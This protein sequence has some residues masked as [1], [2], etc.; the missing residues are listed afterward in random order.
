MS[1]G[2]ALQPAA[3]LMLA[4]LAVL[5]LVL[6]WKWLALAGVARLAWG[7]LYG[8]S[9]QRRPKAS[10]AKTI[11]AWSLLVVAWNTRGLVQK[12]PRRRAGFRSNAPARRQR[13]RVADDDGVPF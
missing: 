12:P 6:F 7:R 10:W 2:R 4:G 8:R 1:G 9:R 13:G 5:A 3:V 11:E